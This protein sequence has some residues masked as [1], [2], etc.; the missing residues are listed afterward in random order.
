MTDLFYSCKLFL[1]FTFICITQIYYLL[2]LS[3]ALSVGSHCPSRLVLPPGQ[4]RYDEAS[5]ITV[6]SSIQVGMLNFHFFTRIPSSSSGGFD[7]PKGVCVMVSVFSLHRDPRYFPDP[8][9][10]NPDRWI[11]DDLATRHPYTYIPFSAGI[12]NCIGQ[13]TVR[14]DTLF[15]ELHDSHSLSCSLS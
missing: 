7:I 5:G 8:E 2:I 10:F 13:Y 3:T 14:C 12:R 9:K 11:S 6:V 4:T 15:L 1:C